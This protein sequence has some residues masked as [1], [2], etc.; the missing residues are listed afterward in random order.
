M[1]ALSTGRYA[2]SPVEDEDEEDEYW[3]AFAPRNVRPVGKSK[4]HLV[5]S[6]LIASSFGESC[7]TVSN[8]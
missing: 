5:C 3:P 8:A 6:A 4:C 7:N 2:G 1:V